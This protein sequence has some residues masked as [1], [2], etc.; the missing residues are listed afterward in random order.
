MIGRGV[1]PPTERMM[2]AGMMAMMAAA[3]TPPLQV[4]LHSA[5]SAP[6][7]TVAEQPNLRK[8]GHAAHR[9]QR[10][11]VRL[12]GTGRRVCAEE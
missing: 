5:V 7:A 8:G 4:P 6:R 3:A 11:A 12:G 9:A 1:P 2:C 10:L